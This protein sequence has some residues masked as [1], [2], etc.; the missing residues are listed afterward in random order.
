MSSFF[1]IIYIKTNRLSD[2]KIA[3]GLLA[4]IN[5]LPEFHFSDYKLNFALKSVNSN[6][7]RSIRKSL[8]RLT[9][10]VNKY[11]NGETT[12]PMFDEPYAKRLLEKLVLKKRGIL[13]YGELFKLEK[14]IVYQK[15][16]KK[17]ISKNF[18]PSESSH[19]QILSFKKRFNQHITHQR[20]DSFFKKK[21]LNDNEFPLLSSP[22][23]VDLFRQKSGFTV[24]K[25]L[26][27]SHTEVTIQRHIAIFRMVVESL[28]KYSS[29]NGLS[30]G[31]YYLVYDTPKTIP[32]RELV[33][34]VKSVYKEFEL[35]QMSEMLDKI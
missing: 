4:N 18:A 21:W 27:F 28:S 26:D 20:F 24:F 13:F 1:T 35:I 6:V 30:K 16:F 3:I 23:Q 33:F 17:Y 32:K 12:I 22:L 29:E 2:E 25:A 8:K 15:L 10:D 19:Y 31:R 11:I 9:N 34:K 7:S 5:D 14:S